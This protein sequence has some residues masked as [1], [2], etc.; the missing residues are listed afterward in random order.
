MRV[1]VWSDDGFADISRYFV[2]L[3][4]SLGYKARLR[5]LGDLGKV[6]AFVNDSRNK[7]QMAA[8]YF[9]GSPSPSELTAPLRCRTFVPNSADSLNTAQFCSREL[10]ARIERA[11]RLQATDPAAAGPAWAAVDRQIVD[12]AP[13]IS[14]LVPEG[15]DLVSTRVSNYQHH[16]VLGVVLSQLWVS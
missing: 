11:L 16:P 10:E 6:L 1:T 13:A 15:I 14:L 7:A 4:N 5:N 2:K 12:Q 8:Y 3:L 9:Y